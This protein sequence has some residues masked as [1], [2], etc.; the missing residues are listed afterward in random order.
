LGLHTGYFN[1]KKYTSSTYS[2]QLDYSPHSDIDD[3]KREEEDRPES[4]LGDNDQGNERSKN[5]TEN[6]ERFYDVSYKYKSIKYQT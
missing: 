5:E 3:N 6:I 1:T 4:L 2:T